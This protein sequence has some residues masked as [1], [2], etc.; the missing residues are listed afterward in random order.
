[1][2]YTKIAR[3]TLLRTLRFYEEYIQRQAF[4]LKNDALTR[5]RL[6]EERRKIYQALNKTMTEAVEIT[7]NETLLEE[8]DRLARTLSLGVGAT[9]QATFQR[10]SPEIISRLVTGTLYPDGIGLSKRVWDI[11]GRNAE[12]I[13]ETI[14]RGVL[15]GTSATELSKK[16]NAFLNDGY[17]MFDIS[18]VYPLAEDTGDIT[19]EA[20][21][22]ARTVINHSHQ[23]AQKEAAR[24]NPFV[25]QLQWHSVLADNTCSLCEERHLQIYDIDDIPLD[26]PNGQCYMTQVAPSLE[27]QIAEI[28]AWE[29]GDDS[30]IDLWY[31]KDGKFIVDNFYRS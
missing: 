23:E 1:M 20:F 28:Q 9:V 22:L 15:E 29:L 7:V 21:R 10:Y 6:L 4:F 31:N 26:H 8:A 25:K 2:D 5:R 24:K 13:W 27:E 16:L 30:R 3:A 18:R 14:T 11:T 19:Y 12:I 17:R